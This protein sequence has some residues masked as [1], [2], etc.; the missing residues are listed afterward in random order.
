[1]SQAALAPAAA[2]SGASRIVEALRRHI[3]RIEGSGPSFERRGKT[4][5][6]RSGVPTIDAHLGRQGLA[7]AGLHD[8]APQAYGDMAAAMG[9]A[10]ALALRALKDDRRPLLWC[11]L[12]RQGQE[13]GRLYGHGLETLGLPR[14]RFVM[15]TL[16]KPMDV[17]WTAEEAVK[18]GALA[19][20]FADADPR[21]AGLTQT[22]RL[23]LAA[24]RGRAACLLVL[25]ARH[26]G[27]TASQT[28]WAVASAPSRAPPFDANAPGKPAWDVEL[29]RSR[30]G[31]PGSWRVEW[32]RAAH[33][34]DL[35]SGV[36]GGTLHPLAD[37]GAAAGAAHALRAG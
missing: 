28:R 37:E 32:S 4:P 14:E 23:A 22:R 21:V 12:D 27:A 13:Y 36:S 11:R 33:R 9:F 35:V 25:A 6:W 10:A 2:P 7:R 18:S 30:A 31:R 17:L 34:F 5:P 26:G 15:V 29:V 24:A 8:V 19:L 20:V 1:M 16:K 3:A